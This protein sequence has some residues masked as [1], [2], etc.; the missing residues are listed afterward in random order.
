MQAGT[1][2]TVEIAG[3]GNGDPAIFDQAVALNLRTPMF[4]VSRRVDEGDVQTGASQGWTRTNKDILQS[5]ALDRVRGIVRDLKKRIRARS[6]PSMFRDGIY[7]VSIEILEEI[8]EMIRDTVPRFWGAVD[9]FLDGDFEAAIDRAEGELGPLFDRS[10]YPSRE[11]ARAEFGFEWSY[12][13]FGTPAALK[14]ISSRFFENAREDARRQWNSALETAQRGMTTEF[15]GL[16]DHLIDRLSP[17][18]DGK[19]KTFKDASIDS[20]REWT[21][22]F[23]KR[24]IGENADLQAAVREAE[25]AMEGIN[26]DDL[27]KE[28]SIR[29]AVRAKFEAVKTKLDAMVVEKGTRKFDFREE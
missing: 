11:E 15:L 3:N 18:A 28:D 9:D 12:H 25:Q 6:S 10:N 16:V 8:D 29:E 22:I 19:K 27:R 20:V 7:L 1:T 4:G 5:K 23:A 17:T 14:R 2:K 13:A 24:K 26:V 21:E